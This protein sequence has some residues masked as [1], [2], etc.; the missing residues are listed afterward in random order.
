MTN[1]KVAVFAKKS[2]L[3]ETSQEKILKQAFTAQ[4]FGARVSGKAWFDKNGAW[5]NPSIAYIL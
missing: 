2:E 1:L 5:Q 4:G 3:A